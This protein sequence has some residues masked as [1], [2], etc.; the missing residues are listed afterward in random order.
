MAQQAQVASLRY[1]GMAVRATTSA[2][3]PDSAPQTSPGL[4][5]SWRTA[6]PLL[7]QGQAVKDLS[8]GSNWTSALAPKSVSQTM[9][10]ASP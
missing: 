6:A 1:P 8:V 7:G 9:S 5:R 4:P 3:P 2:S 10:Y